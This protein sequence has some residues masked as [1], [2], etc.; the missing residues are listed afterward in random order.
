MVSYRKQCLDITLVIVVTGLVCAL[1]DGIE[2]KTGRDLAGEM[3]RTSSWYE[4]DME[5]MLAVQAIAEQIQADGTYNVEKAR[6]MWH[7][8]V[9]DR[10]DQK[11]FG[12]GAHNPWLYTQAH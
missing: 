5:A 3:R 1:M 6:A 4:S 12:Q 10:T 2:R 11:H 7:A 9:Q 8:K